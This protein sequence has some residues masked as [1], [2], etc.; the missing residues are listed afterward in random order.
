VL[1][2]LLSQDGLGFRCWSSGIERG[3]RNPT[4]T[5]ICKLAEA[6][7]VTPSRLLKA[8]EE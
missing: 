2:D 6:L 1:A 7:D 3:V 4:L 5:K 8:A